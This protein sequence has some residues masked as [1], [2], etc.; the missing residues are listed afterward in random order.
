MLGEL[1]GKRN[2]ELEERRAFL[3]D[4]KCQ[5]ATRTETLDMIAKLELEL[6]DLKG[7]QRTVRRKQREGL[8]SHGK[9]ETRKFL[10]DAWPT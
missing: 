7:E 6:E 8:S 2:D 3:D 4:P 5:G 9:K 10:E 1:L